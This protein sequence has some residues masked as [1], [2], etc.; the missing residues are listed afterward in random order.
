VRDLGPGGGRGLGAGAQGVPGPVFVE[1]PVDLLYD[2]ASIRQ[3]YA[4]AAGKGTA[5]PTA[6]CAGT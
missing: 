5:W 2:E 4:D 3:W 6:R 1:C